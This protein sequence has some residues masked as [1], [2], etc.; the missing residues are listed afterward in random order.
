MPRR[1]VGS[2]PDEIQ[3]MFRFLPNIPGQYFTP[4]LA[5]T[6]Q[7]CP[8][9]KVK[10]YKH[11]RPMPTLTVAQPPSDS[12]E[13]QRIQGWVVRR[14]TSGANDVWLNWISMLTASLLLKLKDD[15]FSTRLCPSYRNR[16]A[17]NLWTKVDAI[18]RQTK[19]KNIT[20]RRQPGVTIV[21]LVGFY[22]TW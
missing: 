14:V 2:P 21:S 20:F 15:I 4:L 16:A 13:K 5:A 7:K 3:F 6:S 10:M 12:I 19:R 1:A 17:T 9:K 18:T 22:N 11:T 8:Y